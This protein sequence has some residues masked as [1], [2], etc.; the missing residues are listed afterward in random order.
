MDTELGQNSAAALR[1]GIVPYLNLDG[2]GKAADF[3]KRAFGADEIARM[4]GAADGRLIHCHLVL[5]GNSLM[6]SDPFPEH[7]HPAQTPAAFTLHLQ[8]DDI[9]AWFRRAVAAGATVLM[10]VSKQFWGDLYGRLRDPFGVS[11]SI[12]QTPK[13]QAKAR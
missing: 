4:P 12:G 2:A 6:L 13:D 1:G 5:N 8:V 3:Y 7:G 10:P 11:W 9:D